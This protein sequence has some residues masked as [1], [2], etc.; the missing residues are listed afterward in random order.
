MCANLVP[1]FST[2]VADMMH[3]ADLVEEF[4]T[5]LRNNG[6]E[7]FVNDLRFWLEVQRFK[8]LCHAQGSVTLMREKV[9]R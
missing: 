7:N 4:E 2:F 3:N 1:G 9:R 5:F 6:R 8:S